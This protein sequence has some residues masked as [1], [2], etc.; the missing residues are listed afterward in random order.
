MTQK[1]R[2]RP[3]RLS[4]AEKIVTWCTDEKCF[5]QWSAGILG[6][7]PLTPERFNRTMAAR[8]ES[9]GYF[10]FVAEGEN[11]PAGFFILRRPGEE[12][13]V[14]RFGFVILD[15]ALRGKGYGKAMLRL[16]LGYAFD[17]YGAEKVTL[18]VFE[19]NPGA[20]HCYKS[21]GFREAGRSS[22]YEI[23]GE[24]WNC[25]ELEFTR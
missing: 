1:I 8:D 14:L 20:Y 4:D 24:A 7:Y 10:P 22:T 19:N 9:T 12:T 15:P 17:L 21:L 2:L 18:G 6:R 3:Y 16:G 5:Y 13:E 25:L 23:G 11:G